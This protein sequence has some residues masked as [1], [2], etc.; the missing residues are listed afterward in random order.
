M[1]RGGGRLEKLSNLIVRGV[2]I[3]GRVAKKLNF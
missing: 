3:V 2:G 1:V